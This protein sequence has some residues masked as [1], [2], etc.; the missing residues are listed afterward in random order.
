LVFIVS[1]YLFHRY[2]KQDEGF[3]TKLKT[4]LVRTNMLAK[5]SLYIG[6]DKHIL[7]SKYVEDM[8]GGRTNECILEDTFEA[9]IGALYEDVYRN[10]SNR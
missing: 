3:L 1:Q 7:I 9:F 6:L 4:K 8:C 10:D 5:F 2:L